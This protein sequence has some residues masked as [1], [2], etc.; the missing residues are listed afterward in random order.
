MIIANNEMIANGK[1]V[2]SISKNIIKEFYDLLI[3]YY[4]TGDMIE[5]S[6]FMYNDCIDGINF[7]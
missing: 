5:I 3:E 1:E 7:A 4:E 6:N 2:I